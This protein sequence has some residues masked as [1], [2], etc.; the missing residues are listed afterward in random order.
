MGE[1]S[2]H[3]LSTMPLVLPEHVGVALL[4]LLDTYMIN[5][6]S[7]PRYLASIHLMREICYINKKGMVHVLYCTRLIIH[8]SHQAAFTM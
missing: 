1:N 5:F 6:H 2:D 7:I 8:I 3:Q 4:L